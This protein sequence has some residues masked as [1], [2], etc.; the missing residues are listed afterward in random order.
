MSSCFIR[1]KRALSTPHVGTYANNLGK[2]VIKHINPGN[3]TLVITAN[4]NK[5]LVRLAVSPGVPEEAG[6]KLCANK[7]EKI[8]PH[9]CATLL[10]DSLTL[11]ENGLDLEKLDK[12][13]LVLKESEPFVRK[14]WK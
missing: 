5:C 10:G 4:K 6:S 12:S 8:H 14:S 1:Q 9:F 11:N 2:I 7:R 3:Y 13:C